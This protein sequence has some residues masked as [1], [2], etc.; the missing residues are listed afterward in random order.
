MIIFDIL[1]PALIVLIFISFAGMGPAGLLGVVLA[2][3][4]LAFGASYLAIRIIGIIFRKSRL[5]EF[6]KLSSFKL[7]FIVVA[8][9]AV[10]SSNPIMFL[11]FGGITV[12]GIVIDCYLFACLLFGLTRRI[13]LKIRVIFILILLIAGVILSGLIKNTIDSGGSQITIEE[14]KNTEYFISMPKFNK[15]IKLK[16][17]AYNKSDA[18]FIRIQTWN[19]AFGDLNNDG[20]E[21]AALPLV[22]NGSYNLVVMLNKN[23]KPSY[24]T[25][26]NLGADSGGSSISDFQIQSVKMNSG[27]VSVE[28]NLYSKNTSFVKKIFKYRLSENQLVEAQ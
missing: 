25:Q 23:G 8:A 4:V 14:L 16:N 9:Y 15:L 12:F 3:Y 20:K 27:I 6:T 17:G 18:G 26:K 24:L 2:P 11:G 13:S 7:L 1:V 5:H 21:D 10:I 28:V 22:V 19:I